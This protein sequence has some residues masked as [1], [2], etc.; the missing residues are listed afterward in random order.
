[1]FVFDHFTLMFCTLCAGNSFM[2]Q[3]LI[4]KP[5]EKMIQ[6]YLIKEHINYCHYR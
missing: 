4:G 1:M 3:F 2:M 6:L 5:Y